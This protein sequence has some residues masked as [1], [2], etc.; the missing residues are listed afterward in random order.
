[1]GAHHNHHHGHHHAPHSSSNNQFG[2]AFV[3]A[4]VANGLFVLLQIIAAIN[5]DSTILLADAIHNLGDVLGLAMSW[6][7]HRLLTRTPTDKTTY[8]MKKSSILAAFANGTMLVFT[9]GIIASE[10]IYKLVTPTEVHAFSV[11]IV[12]FIGIIINGVTAML[13]FKGTH[14]LNIKSAYLHLV[15]DALISIG[16]VFSAALLY[17]TGW[18]WIDPV[19]GLIIALLILRG[20]W[21]LFKESLQLIVDGV[22]REISLVQVREFFLAING[23]AQV[24]DLHIWALSTQE[25]ALSVHLLMPDAP[26]TDERRLHLIKRLKEQHN[27]HHV[28]IQI[29]RD[30]RFCDDACAGSQA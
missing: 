16:V 19:V 17:I 13:F 20:T 12:A 27:I 7:A 28:T 5:A 22:P 30:D 6:V 14:D 2:R 18:L 15:Y 1:M 3:V 10:A 25:N 21:S 26:L 9:C 8:G 11:M 29:E 4:I 24:H 23:V